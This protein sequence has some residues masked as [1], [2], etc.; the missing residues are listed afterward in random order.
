MFILVSCGKAQILEKEANS[1]K[2]TSE[3]QI[4]GIRDVQTNEP[5]SVWLVNVQGEILYTTDKGGSWVK[6]KD[7]NIKD[8]EHLFLL[9]KVKVWA[10]T[11]Q[12]TLYVSKDNGNSWE[13]LAHLNYSDQSIV[14]PIL[15][16]SFVD[17]LH[18]WIL[19]PFSIWRTEDGGKSWQKFHPGTKRNKIVEHFFAMQFIDDKVGWITALGGTVYSTI[20]GGKTWQDY[21]VTPT[22]NDV[23]ALYFV[24]EKN[25][26]VFC[27]SNGELF[28]TQDSGKTWQLQ[29]TPYQ[30]INIKSINFINKSE[31]WA[32]GSQTIKGINTPYETHGLILHTTDGGMNWQ[33]MEIEKKEKFYAGVYFNNLEQGW[34]FSS[35]NIY[36]T[37]DIGKTWN[38]V[39]LLTSSE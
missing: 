38:Q 23:R 9:N 16:L 26:W 20:D 21:K 14:G 19:D 32:V 22:N 8:V 31:G 6:I 17:G 15:D 18:G 5:N 2:N 24:D 36:H 25:G 29:S 12:G 39:A 37:D 33:K 10:V 13:Y 27:G 11:S 28:H 4:I 30:N 7:N 1:T 3:A 34:L 35:N